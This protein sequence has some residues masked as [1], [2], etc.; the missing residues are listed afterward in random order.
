MQIK[1]FLNFNTWNMWVGRRRGALM[2]LC[3]GVVGTMNSI[4][5][6]NAC[7][8]CH[9]KVYS[10]FPANLELIQCFIKPTQCTTVCCAPFFF[11]TTRH[12]HEIKVHSNRSITM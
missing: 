6:S 12:D 2:L 1:M 8:R 9:R 4:Q 5:Q 7:T 3:T 11:N 10:R